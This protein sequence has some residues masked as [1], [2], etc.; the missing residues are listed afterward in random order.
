MTTNRTGI[1]R[2]LPVS[3]SSGTIS[4]PH[5]ADRPS[6]VHAL[7]VSELTGGALAAGAGFPAHDTVARHS[8]TAVT[9]S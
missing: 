2:P 3:R 6:T 1:V 9:T 8:E 7:T 5:R 4:V